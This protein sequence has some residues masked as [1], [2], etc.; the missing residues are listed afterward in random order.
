VLSYIGFVTVFSK[1]KESIK[2]GIR[3]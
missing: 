3:V 1:N 2:L